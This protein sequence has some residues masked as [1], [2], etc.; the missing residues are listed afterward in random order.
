MV[1]N[2]SSVWTTNCCIVKFVLEC[3]KNF[4][5]P[6]NFK[7]NRIP[8][9]SLKH[10]FYGFNSNVVSKGYFLIWQVILDKEKQ[11]ATYCEISITDGL[12]H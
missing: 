9:T 7:F 12:K 2:C 8:L 3:S 5:V 1:A 11:R 4:V 6:G 10:S